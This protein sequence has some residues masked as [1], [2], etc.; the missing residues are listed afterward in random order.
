MMS[1]GQELFVSF[2]AS[3]TTRVLHAAKICTVEDDV[4]TFKFVEPDLVPVEAEDACTLFFDGPKEF[5]Q[6]PA[7]RV[8]LEDAADTE[9]PFDLALRLAGEAVSAE[10]RKCYRVGTS[11]A[12]YEGTFGKLGTCHIVDV[13]ATGVGFVSQAKLK[14][15]DSVEFS[16]ELNG[17]SYSGKGFIQS[18]KEVRI[19]NRYGVLCTANNPALAK[20]LQ[21]L[22]MDAQRTQLRRLSGAA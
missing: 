10:S 8:A 11:L 15:G 7:E 20:G 6:Q 22:T 3:G 5:M 17:K 1:P 12:H 14:V 2:P 16:F 13:S 19:G 18:H 4:M 21:L 9:E